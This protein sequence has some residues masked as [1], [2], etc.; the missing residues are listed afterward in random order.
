MMKAFTIALLG[1]PVLD[2]LWFGL[3]MKTFYRQQLAGIARFQDGMLA[4]VWSAVAPVYI[5]LAIGVAVFV[6][7]RAPDVWS[8]AKYGALF[9]LVVY[10]VFDLTNFSTLARYSPILT[11]VDMSWG[12]VAS[13]ACAAAVK[14]FA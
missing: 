12:V 10:G 2:G 13:A 4:P 3:L 5:L 14:T 8:A 1:F 7:P 9:G 6:I 11:V